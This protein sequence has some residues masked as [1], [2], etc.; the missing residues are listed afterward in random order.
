MPRFSES[1]RPT[2][3][4]L[5]M[6]WEIVG[7]LSPSPAVKSQMQMGALDFHKE[8]AMVRRVGSA[9]A[10]MSAAVLA[11]QDAST[12]GSPQ[13][14]PRW[15]RTGSSF[16]FVTRRSYENP[17]T[18]VDGYGRLNPSTNVD[19]FSYDRRVTKLK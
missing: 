14:T 1:T 10:F 13:H 3:L 19:G 12:S 18:F 4:S 9:S 17:S 15:R 8:A 11:A 2:S 6:W 16:S 5:A 7:W